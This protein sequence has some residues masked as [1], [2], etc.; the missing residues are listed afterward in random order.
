MLKFHLCLN[1][2]HED[3]KFGQNMILDQNFV[4]IPNI[5]IQMCFTLCEMQKTEVLV[6]K[7]MNLFLQKEA[8]APGENLC[9]VALVSGLFAREMANFQLLGHLRNSPSNL[10][11][12]SVFISIISGV[13]AGLRKT[14][15]LF[16]IF[17]VIFVF[18]I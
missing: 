7:C 13:M 4:L 5:S 17:V 3:K 11:K 18:G 9:G 6:K 16:C 12:F 10:E 14:V 1:W 2:Q 15:H 8:K